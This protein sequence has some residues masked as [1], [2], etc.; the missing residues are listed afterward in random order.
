MTPVG[1]KRPNQGSTAGP[2]ASSANPRFRE[3]VDGEL[4]E[5]EAEIAAETGHR[6]LSQEDTAADDADIL[7]AMKE[8]APL[9]LN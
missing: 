5:L 1:P 3:G 4:A 2:S 6:L 7:A 9:D 8:D